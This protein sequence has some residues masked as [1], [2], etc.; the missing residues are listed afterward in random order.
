MKR[1]SSKQIFLTV[2]LLFLGRS[3]KCLA[4]TASSG[5]IW[6]PSSSILAIRT[7]RGGNL[8]WSFSSSPFELNPNYEPLPEHNSLSRISKSSS[9]ERRPPPPIP[10]TIYYQS[11]S[12]T[13]TTT[14]YYAS[15]L[16]SVKNSLMQYLSVLHQKSPSLWFITVVS[17]VVFFL[18]QIP[19]FQ[20]FLQKH[21][22]CSRRNV[23]AGRISS[24]FL[25]S[26]SHVSV[27]HLLV[28]LA[29][30]HS[31]TPTVCAALK[32]TTTHNNFPLWHFMLGTTLLSSLGHLALGKRDGCIGMSD[33][34]LAFLA[35]Y[36]R[37][38]PEKQLSLFLMGVI[39]VHMPAQM[40]LHILIIWSIIG[41]F[42]A[43]SNISHVSHL[44]GL[45]CGMAYYELW[46]AKR[47]R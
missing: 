28:N 16:Q 34:T 47:V 3:S 11:Q 20:P 35:I 10:D 26:I 29:T 18:W 32:A 1:Y 42:S 17:P 36:A 30:L 31:F 44:V 6:T 39:P 27:M 4:G 40:L 8:S 23:A 46:Q 13:T 37:M 2:A 21:F 25:S 43:R 5:R 24:I 19:A 15:N 38:F 14:P 22:V 9:G 45:L 12:F 41:C 33:I 7:L